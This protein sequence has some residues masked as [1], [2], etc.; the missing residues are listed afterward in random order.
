MG[1]VLFASGWVMLMAGM[2]LPVGRLAGVLFG[3]SAI[4]V[5]LYG[6]ILLRNLAG[7]AD[8]MGT[9]WYETVQKPIENFLPFGLRVPAAPC[10][11]RWMGLGF[12]VW[13][14][15]VGWI[16]MAVIVGWFAPPN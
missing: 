4:L 7:V 2:L 12:V 8:E 14:V 11:G 13:G 10:L 1:I 5:V 9:Q 6:A 3:G 16:A 15:G